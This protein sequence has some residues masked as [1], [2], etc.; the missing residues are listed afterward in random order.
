MRNGSLDILTALP[1]WQSELLGFLEKH[2]GNSFR[3]FSCVVIVGS[4]ARLLREPLM[5]RFKEKAFLSD[6]PIIAT[7]RGLYKYM[8]MQARRKA[9]HG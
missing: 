8:L 4:G 1:I 7:A 3:R 9:E 2:W 5:L 6:D